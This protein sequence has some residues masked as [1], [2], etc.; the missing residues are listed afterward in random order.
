MDLP[1]LVLIH[2]G[3]HAAD[4]WDLTI[5]E[6]T[7]REP[8]LR[9]LAVDLPG[10]GRNP[11][12]LATVTIADW[13]NSVVAD[14]EDAMLSDLVV[15]GHSLGGLTVP[16]VVARLGAARVREMVLA[17]AFIPPQGLS[18]VDTLRGP[19]APL[20]RIGPRIHK[21]ATIPKTAARLAFCNA[22]SP[23]QRRH[24][25]SRLYPES[26]R[27]IAE[28]VD[29]SDLPA[30]VPRTWIMTLRDRA[31]SSRQQQRCIE[32]LGG[33]DTL[34]CLDTCHDLMYSEPQRLA[35]ILLERLRFRARSRRPE[36]EKP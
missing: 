33:V 30:E 26:A 35:A 12:D 8:K 2:G 24:A 14:V 9:V 11:A 15:V 27:V 10:R 32:S 13:V 34:V 18:V 21:L 23:E 25:L 36:R 20:A 19:L 28:R 5:A 1:D 6:L 22:M 7:C 29:R 3:A 17:A 31:L 16:G 4:C